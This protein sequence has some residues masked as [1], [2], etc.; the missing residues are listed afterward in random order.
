[1]SL[2]QIAQAAI[3][4]RTSPGPGSVI[5]IVSMD[6]GSPKAR[7]TAALVFMDDPRDLVLKPERGFRAAGRSSSAV[8]RRGACFFE[9]LLA[10]PFFGRPS[11]RPTNP[12]VLMECSSERPSKS[13]LLNQQ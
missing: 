8:L 10:G 2:W 12:A 13:I 11:R 3:L 7:Q 4:T 9:G 1:M 5:S 6:S